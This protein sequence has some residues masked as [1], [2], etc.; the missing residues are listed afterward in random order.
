LI[1]AVFAGEG[2]GTDDTIAVDDGGPHVEVE[3]AIHLQA[4]GSE[5]GSK[6]AVRR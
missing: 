2:H 3:A 5:R 6:C 4:C 1:S